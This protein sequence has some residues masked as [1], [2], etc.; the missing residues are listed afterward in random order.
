[1]RVR[2]TGD[3]IIERAPMATLAP[4]LSLFFKKVG[5][6]P[7]VLHNEEE[8]DHNSSWGTGI[9]TTN[10]QDEDKE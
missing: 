5:Y 1:M 6:C 7:G 2:P 3:P 9:T 10:V 4:R 8:C